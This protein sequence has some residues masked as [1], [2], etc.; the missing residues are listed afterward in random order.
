MAVD[1]AGQAESKNSIK[2]EGSWGHWLVSWGAAWSAGDSM[3]FWFP[4]LFHASKLHSPDI[5]KELGTITEE[6]PAASLRRQYW[7]TRNGNNSRYSQASGMPGR[8]ELPRLKEGTGYQGVWSGKEENHHN[9]VNENQQQK[10]A[11]CFCESGSTFSVCQINFAINSL[12]ALL[13]GFFF[14]LSSF[15]SHGHAT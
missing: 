1:G 8:Q 7:G 12:C 4:S 15:S 13:A 9:T 2:L 11:N 10:R 6:C 14:P 5:C 3:A